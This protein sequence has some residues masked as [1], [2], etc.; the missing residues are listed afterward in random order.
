LRLNGC[1]AK[2]AGCVR[3]SRRVG[4]CGQKAW[5]HVNVRNAKAGMVDK[6]RMRTE[7]LGG[8]YVW[9]DEERSCEDGACLGTGMEEGREREQVVREGAEW[10]G[11]RGSTRGVSGVGRKRYL[12]PWSGPPQSSTTPPPQTRRLTDSGED[13]RQR[14]RG[15]H[16][17]EGIG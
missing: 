5:M 17:R 2:D 10:K 13:T 15:F 4:T 11:G 12:R 1:E 3:G 6:G 14:K 7:V 16:P 9:Q 8:W